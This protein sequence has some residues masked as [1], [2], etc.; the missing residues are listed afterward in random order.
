[1]GLYGSDNDDQGDREL[2]YDIPGQGKLLYLNEISSREIVLSDILQMI[3]P[4]TGDATKQNLR[5][6]FRGIRPAKAR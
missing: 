4:I 5:G 1:M 6:T 2:E 3:R